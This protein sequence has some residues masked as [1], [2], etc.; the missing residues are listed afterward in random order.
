MGSF[1]LI[2]VKSGEEKMPDP[3]DFSCKSHSSLVKS[4]YSK[5]KLNLKDKQGI[6]RF[7][8]WLPVKKASSYSEKPITYRSE[9]LA[10]ELGLKN[11]FISFNGYWPEKGVKMETITFKELEGA[12][13]LQYAR[14]NNVKK[15]VVAS[16]GNTGKAFASSAMKEAFP[17]ILV[18]PK[19]CLC[20][21]YLPDFDNRYVKI[22]LLRDGD[23]SDSIALARRIAHIKGYTYEG[24]AKNIA[25]RDGLATV[26]LDAAT[27][28]GRLPQHYLQAVGS[29]T[30]AIATYEAS[31]R[32]IGD[33]GFG[34]SLPVFHLSQNL[35]VAPMYFAWQDGR[36]EIVPDK[37]IPKVDNVLDLIYAR[38]LSNRYPP[39]SISG[40]VYDT[41]KATKGNMYGVENN[42]ARRAKK[43]FAKVEGIDIL[44]A[45]AVA[46]ASLEQA[47]S[48]NRIKENDVTLLNI[49][50]G[51]GRRLRKD[52]H[53]C[54]IRSDYS[55]NNDTSNDE[56][57]EL[58]L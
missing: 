44:P 21:V 33:G 25:R 31:L 58:D 24:G 2:C 38:V 5:K 23:Y 17:V 28:I 37:D 9:G 30:G 51:G 13:T 27:V 7:I 43:L 6:W 18:I 22:I 4:V 26:M 34:S 19:K 29:G 53:L 12:V 14:E 55:V 56:L 36:R 20:G 46:V 52:M 10:A 39:Y 41:L 15:L 49:T 40:G 3:F 57:K 35:P 42:E 50:G 47:V 32:L 54:R 8:D 1:K 16:A 11:L 48:R 45:A